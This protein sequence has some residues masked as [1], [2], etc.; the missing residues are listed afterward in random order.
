MKIKVDLVLP[1]ECYE[2][3][4]QKLVDERAS[5]VFY[6]VVMTLG[7]ILDGL[8]FNEYIKRGMSKHV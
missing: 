8:F 1:D 6:R 4:K 7:Q 5:P 3:V 2:L